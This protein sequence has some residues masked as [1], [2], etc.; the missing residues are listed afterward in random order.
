MTQ[1]ISLSDFGTSRTHR[2]PWTSEELC[3]LY[4]NYHKL[5]LRQLSCLI[6]SRSFCAVKNKVKQIKFS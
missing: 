2:E 3:I 6:P 4:Q 1:K 5:N